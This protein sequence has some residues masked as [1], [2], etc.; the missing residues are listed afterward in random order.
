MIRVLVVSD[1]RLLRDGLALHLDRD[2]RIDLV[3]TAPG[4]D[5]CLRHVAE[6]PPEVLLLDVTMPQSLA[7]L[8]EITVVAPGTR[9]VAVAIS[10]VD[11]DV[12]ACVE[13]GI[14]GYVP[15]DGSLE[16]LVT[17]IESVVRGES[18]IPPRMTASL[19]Q[20]LVALARNRAT[21]PEN[22]TLTAREREITKL[23]EQGKSNKE[24]AVLLG[25]EVPTVKNHVHRILA[26]FQLHRRGEIAGCLRQQHPQRWHPPE[27]RL[28]T[29]GR[30]PEG[31]P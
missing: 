23:I 12:L 6:H 28:Q 20:R 8:R 4:P 1:M 22:V 31:A 3:G 18:I 9:V 29:G 27:S 15:R 24:V 21:G 13:A 25:I 11:S 30:L 17:T 10:D 19:L 26:K 16:D 5:D 14:A 7:T 2:P